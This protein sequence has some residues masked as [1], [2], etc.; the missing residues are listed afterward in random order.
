MLKD[1]EFMEK[2]AEVCR[3]FEVL[4]LELFG[5][6]ATEGFHEGQSDVDLLVEFLP[7]ARVRPAE[8][9]F[10]L[11][12]AL[13]ELFQAELDLVSKSAVRNERFR[14]ELKDTSV[15]IFAA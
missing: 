15:Q 9:Y 10:G 12:E 5:S 1:Q 2:L 4:R 8:R 13:S 11:K 3:R 14:Q 6:A 7:Q